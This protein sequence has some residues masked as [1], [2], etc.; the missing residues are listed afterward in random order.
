MI[1]HRPVP[2]SYARG[3][4]KIIPPRRIHNSR[5]AGPWYIAVSANTT[6]RNIAA[7]CDM[8]ARNLTGMSDMPVRYLTVMSDMTVRYLAVMSGDTAG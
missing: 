5:E 7:V 2:W 1:G 6:A 3:R 4:A 8:T